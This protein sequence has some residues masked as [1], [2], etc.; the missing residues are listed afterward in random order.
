MS[1]I[2]KKTNG[3]GPEGKEIWKRRPWKKIENLK[4]KAMEEEREVEEVHEQEEGT[5]EKED[6]GRR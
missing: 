2:F 4:K 5:F 3:V 6:H 1:I